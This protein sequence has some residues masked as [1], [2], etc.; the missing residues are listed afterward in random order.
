MS[1]QERDLVLS[2][3]LDEQDKRYHLW[4]WVVMDDHVH[5]VVTLSMGVQLG[6]VLHTWKSFSAH[7]LQRRFGR[8]GQVWQHES[9]DRIIRNEHELEQNCNYIITNP[10]RRLPGICDYKWCGFEWL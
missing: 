3:L 4:A 7:Q 9:Y 5:V 2:I 10:E 6:K 1:E 8:K